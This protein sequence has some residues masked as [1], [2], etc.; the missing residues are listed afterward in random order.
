VGAGDAV[1]VRQTETETA[2]LARRR[3]VELAEVVEHG[4]EVISRDPHAPVGNR[5][6]HRRPVPVLVDG[7]RQHDLAARR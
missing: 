3:P 7:R 6:R 2:V 1:D 4:L 5:Q